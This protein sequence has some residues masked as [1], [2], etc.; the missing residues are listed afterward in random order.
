MLKQAPKS[1]AKRKRLFDKIS[2]LNKLFSKNNPK[3]T[4]QN[5]NELVT[6]FHQKIKKSS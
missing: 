3:S 2:F 6:N 5:Y 4:S 1:N